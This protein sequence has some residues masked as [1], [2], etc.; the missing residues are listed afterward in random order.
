MPIGI[1]G[2]IGWWCPSLDDAGNG[3]STIYDLSGNGNDLTL[4]NM[5]PLTDW[6][7]DTGSGGVRAIDFNGFNQHATTG[8]NV[9]ILVSTRTTISCW[10]KV[11]TNTN[12]LIV[13]S[14][15]MGGGVY[16]GRFAT[17]K[18]LFFFDNTTGNNSSSDQS[19]NGLILN[20]WY[21]LLGYNDGTTT[22]QYFNGVYDSQYSD[23]L[24]PAARFI[25]IG[26]GVPPNTNRLIGRMD[27]IRFFDRILTQEEITN[28]ASS[29][30]YQNTPNTRRR[31]Y[32]GGY[33]L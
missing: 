8:V 14:G 20:R 2:E 18:F 13:Q 5:D 3:T 4:T 31:R 32:A 33:G 23:I 26:Q 1:G 22:Y 9:P 7:A 24:S 16:L 12:A 25:T 21:H 30:G 15:S 27:D 11:F 17:A 19:I 28:L 6:V 10:V 29:R